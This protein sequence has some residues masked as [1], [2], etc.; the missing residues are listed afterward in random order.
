MAVCF[1]FSFL[2]SDNSGVTS[3]V[4]SLDELL[5]LAP[6]DPMSNVELLKEYVLQLG[7]VGTM[8]LLS[9]EAVLAVIDAL[10]ADFAWLINLLAANAAYF[11]RNPGGGVGFPAAGGG[12]ERPGPLLLPERSGGG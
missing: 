11:A 7:W 4:H 2:G 6:A 8:P 5:G 10:S 9:H 1:L 3:F 12:G